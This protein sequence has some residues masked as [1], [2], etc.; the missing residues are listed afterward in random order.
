MNELSHYPS[1]WASREFR[2]FIRVYGLYEATFDQDVLG[3]LGH[4]STTV[5]TSSWFVFENLHALEQ[6]PGGCG[7]SENPWCKGRRGWSLGLLRV[8]QGAWLGWCAGRERGDSV[9]ER[10][11]LLAKL[12]EDELLRRHIENDHVPYLKGCPTCIAAQGRQRSHWRAGVT[13]LYSISC[14]LAGPFKDGLGFDATASGRDRGRGYKYFLSA[15]YFR[16][17]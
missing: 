1:V 6:D 10:K 17:G 9:S 11:A 8:I 12:T 13:S 15:A 16:T 2:D 3:G 14:D 4:G 7:R 5:A